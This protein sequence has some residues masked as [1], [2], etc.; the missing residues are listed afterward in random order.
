MASL[1]AACAELALGSSTSCRTLLI[2]DLALLKRGDFDF[3][4]SRRRV[5][6]SSSSW[7]RTSA[8]ILRNTYEIPAASSFTAWRL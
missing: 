5:V 6:A 8:I 7:P 1:R 2:P 3:I 4:E